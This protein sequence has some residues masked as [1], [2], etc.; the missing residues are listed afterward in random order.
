MRGAQRLIPAILRLCADIAEIGEQRLYH[1]GP[2]GNAFVISFIVKVFSYAL[3]DSLVSLWLIRMAQQG[4]QE[5]QHKQPGLEEGPEPLADPLLGGSVIPRA[6]DLE[7]C[8]EQPGTR[9]CAVHAQL[10][11]QFLGDLHK[12]RPTCR[13]RKQSGKAS[14]RPRAH[15][16]PPSKTDLL[17]KIL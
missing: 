14:K 1:Y 13:G 17:W 4:F 16:K 9:L 11:L 5:S 3:C 15:R 6:S 8:E 7:Y 12:A 10:T 2:P